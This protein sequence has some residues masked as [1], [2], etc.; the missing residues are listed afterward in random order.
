MPTGRD[1]A[2]NLILVFKV[3]CKK[4]QWLMLYMEK[5]CFSIVILKETF[6]VLRLKVVIVYFDEFHLAV[7]ISN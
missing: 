7:L 4:S 1:V 3:C 6:S 5:F 2:M